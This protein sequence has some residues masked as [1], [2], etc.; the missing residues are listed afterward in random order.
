MIQTKKNSNKSLKYQ[1]S[2]FDFKQLIINLLNRITNQELNFSELIKLFKKLE[3]V[4]ENVYKNL[5]KK[6]LKLL[7]ETRFNLIKCNSNYFQSIC[8]ISKTIK[9]FKNFANLK[10]SKYNEVNEK[11]IQL[12]LIRAQIYRKHNYFYLEELELLNILNNQ[13]TNSDHNPIIYY[14]LSYLFKMKGDLQT[15][16]NYIN[17]ASKKYY[18]KI[19]KRIFK[20]IQKFKLQSIK[21]QNTNINEI[22]FIEKNKINLL[23]ILNIINKINLKPKLSITH[24]FQ[25]FKQSFN[26]NN[27]N[28]LINCLF[29]HLID[30]NNDIEEYLKKNNNTL[31]ET[32]KELQK[33]FANNRNHINEENL[34]E[35]FNKEFKTKLK[36]LF[37]TEENDSIDFQYK[38]DEIPIILLKDE[39]SN[40]Y[41]TT[42]QVN[43]FM[44]LTTFITNY[45]AK[46]DLKIICSK[47]LDIEIS[48][49]ILA[50]N[51]ENK[52]IETFINSMVECE[53]MKIFIEEVV[54]FLK[55]DD[56]NSNCFNFWSLIANFDY[57]IDL[58]DSLNYFKELFI[59]SI[60]EYKKEK[61]E[62]H[63][64]ALELI[65]NLIEE[66]ENKQ[67]FF[68]LLNKLTEE[69]LKS[70]SIYENVSP[71]SEKRKKLIN[72][73][74]SN[75]EVDEKLKQII[76]IDC[77]NI[78]LEFNDTNEEELFFKYLKNNDEN[79]IP[80]LLLSIIEDSLSKPAII[81]DNTMI[82]IK[83][84]NILL[85]D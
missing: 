16:I 36:C 43:H 9:E 78:N 69:I 68:N 19:N 31:T 5:D 11:I 49:N 34:I 79:E 74:S 57:N 13:K 2:N 4:N 66:N 47:F 46:A 37:I 1:L 77:F 67:K 60:D 7:P 65:D 85:N 81:I 71:N 50:D 22:V 10:T 18:E 38:K 40:T 23:E 44:L 28:A 54:Y 29:Y 70:L 14:R 35:V 17:L 42:K 59:E 53:S 32:Y 8:E 64:S 3:L 33:A 55:S 76:S 72:I 27:V 45:N 12:K 25:L 58:K 84:Y 26:C 83:S 73:M 56:Y 41:A 15:S 48:K 63:K 20:K 39:N 52:N 24:G 82:T 6:F 61:E 51:N 80:S 30:D 75:Y 62:Q 21:L